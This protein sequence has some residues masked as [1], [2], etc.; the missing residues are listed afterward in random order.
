[1][2]SKKIKFKIISPERIV[3]DEEVDELSTDGVCGKFG[4]LPDHVPFM[5]P[6]AIGVT[7]VVQ[8]GKEEFIATMGGT[9]QVSANEATMLT[10]AAERSGEIDVLRAQEA[11]ENAEKILGSKAAEEEIARANVSKA[12]AVARLKAAN[13]QY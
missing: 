9:F 13:K 7:K 2:S 4:I 3:F 6:V 10:N 11:K 1:M 5:T 8:D 12:K